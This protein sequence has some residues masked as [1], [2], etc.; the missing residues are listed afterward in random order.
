MKNSIEQ[1]FTDYRNKLLLKQYSTNTIDMYCH[2][3]KKFLDSFSD[4]DTLSESQVCNYVLNQ[5]CKSESQQNIIINTIK[6]YYEKVRYRKRKIYRLERPKTSQKLPVVCSHEEIVS[7]IES[8]KNT[9]HKAIISLAYSVGL[10]VSE[11]VNL[12]IEDIDSKRMIITIRQS[13]GKKDRQVPLSESLL[14]LLRQYY[15]EYKPR[16]FLFNGQNS[17]Q[18]SIGSCQAIYDR[19]KKTKKSTFHSLRHSCFTYLL[20]QGTDLRIIQ[21]LAGHSNISTTQIYTHVSSRVL[22]KLRLPV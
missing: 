18:Y 11:V 14:Q 20:E 12:K 13:K 1:N 19:Y 8:I 9:K 15:L 6:F 16:E 4:I 2:Y 22:Q 3:F 5:K 17:I 7:V 21:E 10:R